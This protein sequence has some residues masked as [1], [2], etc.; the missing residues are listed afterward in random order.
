MLQTLKLLLSLLTLFLFFNASGQNYRQI[1]FEPINGQFTT[2]HFLSTT[3]GYIGIV[4]FQQPIQFSNGLEFIPTGS[5]DIIIYSIDKEGHINWASAMNNSNLAQIT[6]VNLQPDEL[7]ILCTGVFWDTLSIL[8]NHYINPNGGK[9]IFNAKIDITTG[10]IQWVNVISGTGSTKQS[11]GICIQES[12]KIYSNGWFTESLIL[13]DSIALNTENTGIYLIEMNKNGAFIDA[14]LIGSG[15]DIRTSLCKCAS[16]NIYM[17]GAFRGNIEILGTEEEGRIQDFEAMVLKL[18]QNLNLKWINTG[19]GV[20]D[21]W[22]IDL[23]IS[24]DSIVAIAGHF[25]GNMNFKDGYNMRSMGS[26]YDAFIVK[27]DENGRAFDSGVFS[28]SG[29]YFF[30]K[31]NRKEDTYA[32]GGTFDGS[33]FLEHDTFQSP[34]GS[35]SACVIYWPKSPD[36]DSSTFFEVIGQVAFVADLYSSNDITTYAV[37]FKGILANQ[38]QQWESL[39]EYRTLILESPVPNY[40]KELKSLKSVNWLT[41]N[42][43][44]ENLFISPNVHKLLLYDMYG[45]LVSTSSNQKHF[46]VESIPSGTYIAIMLTYDGEITY[47]II[48]KK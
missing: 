33:L 44:S 9:A 13:G 11:G 30:N 4:G 36:R 38:N 26:L 48:V 18:D 37:N 47:Q 28:S 7:S 40:L 6:G 35:R 19:K 23:D 20:L 21:N 39:E 24:E 16:E 12:G 45:K 27:L 42:P 46:H 5:Q 2:Q 34:I 31:L 41:P 14:V 29:T 32:L 25:A 22:I 15:L 3:N 10:E 17:A 8:G 43:V 1:S